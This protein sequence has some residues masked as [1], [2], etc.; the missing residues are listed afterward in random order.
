MNRSASERSIILV[1]AAVQFVNILDFVMVM[2]LGQFFARDLHLV[3]SQMGY[4]SGAYAVSGSL[5][6]LLGSLVLDRFDRRQALPLAIVGL[7]MGTAAGAWARSL[8]TIVAARL[9]AGF[10]GGPATSLSFAIVADVI[11]EKRRGRAMSVVMTALSVAQVVGVPAGLAVARYWGWRASFLSV[12]ALALALAMLAY[13]VLPSLRPSQVN[14]NVA[15]GYA[16]LLG[17]PL[18]LLSYTMTAVT[19]FAGFL[20]VPNMPA[21][22][23]G[24]LRFPVE[25]LHWIYALSGLATVFTI[26]G[27]GWL[28]DRFGSFRMGSVGVGLSIVGSYCILWIP[29]PVFPQ[30][31]RWVMSLVESNEWFV[32]AFLVFL[33][34][35]L[36]CR[37]VAYNTLATKVPEP[38]LRARFNSLQS[39]V[40]HFASAAGSFGSSRLLTSGA[41]LADAL[42]RAAPQ[43]LI[44]MGRV[45]A[46]SIAASALL[47]VLL[48]MVESRVRM[49]A[50]AAAVAG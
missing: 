14:R 37:N 15:A 39:C 47:P 36:S 32:A 1:V 4:V 20:L 25:D 10:F 42:P 31:G 23:T 45:V 2:P 7:A 3:M 29:Q 8:E 13:R 9:L 26:R 24:N 34:I 21:Y 33:M 35:A 11:P 16:K 22:L 28:V 50:A 41:V 27:V 5:A 18:V 46:L 43:P 44:G 40:Q 48:G 12:A 49:R 19:M 6:G 38:A 30:I 17:N